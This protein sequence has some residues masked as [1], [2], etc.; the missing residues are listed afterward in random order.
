MKDITDKMLEAELITKTLMGSTVC[1]MMDLRVVWRRDPLTVQEQER[2]LARADRALAA[3]AAEPGSV[4]KVTCP[5]ASELVF[6]AGA[7]LKYYAEAGL[8]LARKESNAMHLEFT[9]NS[10]IYVVSGKVK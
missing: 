5:R 7:L 8:E 3:A 10:A 4:V 1:G 9:N 6:M 2:V